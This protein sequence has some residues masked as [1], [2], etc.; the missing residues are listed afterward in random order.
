M[1]AVDSDTLTQE[2]ANARSSAGVMFR[3]RWVVLVEQDRPL[4]PA[5]WLEPPCGVESLRGVGPPGGVGPSGGVELPG[6][7]EQTSWEEPGGCLRLSDAM[8][9][10]KSEEGRG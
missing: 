8:A 5:G 9:V 7:V 2:R 6:G 1:S 10:E 3:P 4:E